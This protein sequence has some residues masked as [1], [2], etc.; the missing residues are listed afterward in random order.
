MSK[1]SSPKTVPVPKTDK[2]ESPPS[3][4]KKSQ[5]PVAKINILETCHE[6]AKGGMVQFP[7]LSLVI[8]NLIHINSYIVQ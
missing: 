5:T 6:Y 8:L 3:V 7:S 1:V 2:T 4:E